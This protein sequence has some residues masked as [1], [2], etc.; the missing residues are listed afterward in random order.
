MEWIQKFYDVFF[1]M[2]YTMVDRL[3]DMTFGKILNIH[4]TNET[5]P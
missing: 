2:K 3:F 5:Q 1:S 4:K